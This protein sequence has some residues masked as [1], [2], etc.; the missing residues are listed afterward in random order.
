MQITILNGNPEGG[1]PAFDQYVQQVS[2]ACTT[3]GDT[4]KILEIRK[5]N[6][7]YCIGCFGCWNK[8]PGECLFRDDSA[9]LDRS[10]IQ[11][12]F[13]L[14]AAPLKMGF[15]SALQ[16]KA[17]D[18]SIPLIHPYFEAVYNESHHMRRYDR[19]PRMGLLIE[20]EADTDAADLEIVTQ[21]MARMALNM[22]SRLEFSLT[23]ETPTAEIAQQ[24]HT[25][26]EKLLFS[27]KVEPTVG[28]RITPPKRLT[29]I[30]GSPRGPKGN[31]PIMLREFA[32][33][34]GGPSETFHLMPVKNM[35][36]AVAAFAAAECVWLG[37]P[38][39]TD[40]MPGSVKHYIEALEPFKG[41][42]NNPALGFMVQS[43]FP[44]AAHSRYIE[45]YLEKLAHRLG[46]AYAGTIVKGNG[47]GIRLMSDSY[48]RKLFQDLRQLGQGLASQG[49]LDPQVL[50]RVAGVERYPTYL[51]PLLKL[52]V[53]L[54]IATMYWDSELK[55][56][57][58]YAQRFAQPYK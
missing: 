53:K 15:P 57:G 54:P 35:D 14:F 10:I 7:N 28:Q 24:F 27:F 36:A 32:A 38:L 26:T 47:E 34:F 17:M 50:R 37:F 58:A 11:S 56:N 49:T 55:K 41:R 25:A 44:E 31:T 19:Y 1:S 40:A 8:T 39:Y 5:L 18:R 6:L 12:D 52:F 43:G 13:V 46:C 20:R 9:E 4:V 3:R 30:N 45:R 22:K 51:M 33:G 21:I 23:T 48:N 42:P 2:T 16:K 29:L